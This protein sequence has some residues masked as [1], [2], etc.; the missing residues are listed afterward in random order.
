LA[1]L[2]ALRIPVSER[3]SD[4]EFVRRAYL[5]AI[6]TLPRADEVT[7]FLDDP[8]PD[9]RARLIE[10]LIERPEYVSYWS[11]KW[12]DV[13]LVSSRKLQARGMRAYYTYVRDSV[14][15]NKPFDRFAYDILTAS[16]NSAENG[17]VNYFLVQKSPIDLAE[18]TT[19]AFL[20]MRLTC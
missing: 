9:K 1:K 17:A 6:G 15:A 7:H 12:S 16:G 19:Q 2:R 10:R 5:D 14:A 11:F 13:L 20:G 18:N 3:S 4:A 8:S